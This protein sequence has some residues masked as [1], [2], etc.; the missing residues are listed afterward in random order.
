MAS[1]GHTRTPAGAPADALTGRLLDGRYRV[2][3]RVARGG[4]ASVYEA[5][6]IRLDR[7]VA[8]KVMHP[9]LGD[10]DEFAAR[11]VR[12]AR[13]AA[14][15][16]HPNVVSV[17]DQG[18][19]DGVV[20]LAM[21]LVPGH[22]LRDTIG[23]ESP[24]SPL[25]AL[26]LLEPVL[27]ALAAA[28]RAG[29]IH[30]DVKPENV[31]IADDGRV[32]VADFGLAKA[33]SA[34]TQHTATGGVLIGTVSYLAPELVV[35][36][37]A[38][39]RADVYAAGVLLYELLTG[40][41]PHEGESPI[42]VAYKHV[43]ED[44]PPPSAIAPGLPAYVDALVARATARDRGQRPADAAVL[45]HHVHRVTQ[46][47]A[48]GVRE[49]DELTADLLPRPVVADGPEPT[50]A[51][52]RRPGDTAPEIWDAEEL[53]RILG[54][55]A[56]EP[57]RV[58]TPTPPAGPPTA[59]APRPAPEPQPS[60]PRRPRRSR[61]GLVLLV[62]AVL[63]AC[64]VGA[65]AWW[66]GSG[67]Y[68]AVPGVVSLQQAAAVE[69]LEAA[70]LETEVGDPAYSETV[71]A[72]VVI[73]TDPGAGEQVLDGG[74]VTITVSRGKERYTLPALAGLTLDQATA[75]IA[76][77]NLSLGTVKERWSETV[78]A[79]TVIASSPGEGKVLA[80]G[81]N[82]DLAVSKGRRPIKVGDWAG[83]SY[84]D[85][86]AAL[87][88][89]GLVAKVGDEQYSDDV[90]EGDVIGQ[91]PREGTLFKGETVTFTVSLGPELVEVPNVRASGVEDARERLEDLGFVVRTTEAAGYLG[92]GYVFS[93][94]PGAGEMV[95]KGSTI[96]LSL[97]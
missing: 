11:F 91:D 49:D 22:T 15:L 57:T 16:S 12:E 86:R 92:L 42:Q 51:L 24:M 96:T 17:H 53:G 21:E 41:K 33:V 77:L 7:T 69:K 2:G 39:A 37:R 45:L 59:R 36:G 82:I 67:R 90:P 19:D 23:K 93:T 73:A 97:I 61:R 10:D 46:A 14:R 87:E 71:P 76:D 63:L 9:G 1:D 84:D 80:R 56:T 81:A 35:D 34:D 88:K 5:T 54:P 78:A 95:A 85:A 28:H 60:R 43:H 68:T 55:P 74:T 94:D 47:L 89:R 83:R 31:L 38:D 50:V 6:D 40:R 26:A 48:D 25:R 18:E 52:E 75:Q 4:M 72:G 30:R 13:A 20:F 44:V 58:R 32:K 66:F 29:L 62:V 27:S 3:P 65:G 79:G 8:V 70:G 64:G